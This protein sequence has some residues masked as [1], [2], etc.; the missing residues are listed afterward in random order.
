MGAEPAAGERRRRLAPEARRADLLEHAR[1]VLARTGPAGFTLEGV[2]EVAG[3]TPPLLRH[4]FGGRDG[5]FATLVERVVAE[6][7][8]IFVGSPGSGG[9]ADRLAAYLDHTEANPWG[10]GVWMHASVTHPALAGLIADARCQLATLSFGQEWTEM[11]PARRLE[12]VGWIGCA[13]ALVAEWIAND[14][15]DRD[16]VLEALLT[17]ARRFGVRGL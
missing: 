8:Q 10:H 6:V 1:L 14:F 3:V 4:Y 5:L 16:D 13:E 7:L 2:A 11:I 12:A 15:S 17:A 9:L